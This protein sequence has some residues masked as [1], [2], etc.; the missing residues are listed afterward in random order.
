MLTA[1]GC[2]SVRKVRHEDAPRTSVRFESLT[3]SVT[4]YDAL[5]WKK[6]PG[7]G[8]HSKVL[9]GQTLYARETRPSANVVFNAAAAAADVNGDGMILESEAEAFA[10]S[11]PG[12]RR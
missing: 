12:A 11:S 5:L 3:A 8:K 2:V 1:T 6:F 4:F 10:R 9:L 7:A